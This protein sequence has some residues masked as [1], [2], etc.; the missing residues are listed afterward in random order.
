MFAAAVQTKNQGGVWG[1]KPLRNVTL[2][3]HI[4]FLYIPCAA[5]LVIRAL[6][7]LTKT[8]PTQIRAWHRRQQPPTYVQADRCKNTLS[9]CCTAR[10]VS[11]SSSPPPWLCSFCWNKRQSDSCSAYMDRSRS[12]WRV[13]SF[14]RSIRYL[15]GHFKRFRCRNNHACACLD[16]LCLRQGGM[17]A[18]TLTRH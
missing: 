8:T 1:S 16:L 5:I 9:M 7:R 3:L 15:D 18:V 2:N 14:M 10:G 17:G 4:Y 6:T 11:T 13:G 12:I